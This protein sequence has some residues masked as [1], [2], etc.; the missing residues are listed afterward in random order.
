MVLVPDSTRK[1]PISE[2]D[3]EEYSIGDLYE[4][5]MA[6][7]SVVAPNWT[8][9]SIANPAN[10][11]L[12]VAS[13]LTHVMQQT[14]NVA[15][16][17]CF[18]VTADKREAVRALARPFYAVKELV[19]A[20]SAVQFTFAVPHPEVTIPAR[21]RL[22]T[23]S[24]GDLPV[25][26]FETTADFLVLED[27]AT[28]FVPV[29][30]GESV[31][32]EALGSSDGSTRQKFYLKRRPVVWESEAI[33]VFDGAAWVTWSRVTDFVESLST[34]KHYTIA[35]DN[36][37]WVYLMFGDGDMGAIP[38]AGTNNIRATY[39][40]GGGLQGNVAANTITDLLSV[41][42][43]V[44]SVTNPAAATG[45]ADA[46]S[47][48]KA[49]MVAIAKW[50]AQETGLTA[51]AIAA[52]LVDYVSD[53]YGAI[54]QAVAVGI[55]NLTI[56]VRFVPATGGV[57][58]AG[59]KAEIEAF[60]NQSDIK[61]VLTENKVSDPTFLAVDYDL[62]IWIADGYLRD[63]VIEQVRQAIVR[64]GSPIYRDS[65]GIYPN[66][67]GQIV[68]LS[69]LS[70]EIQNVPGIDYLVINSPATDLTM[71]LYQ[72]RDINSIVIASNLGGVYNSR[73]ILNFEL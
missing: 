9:D 70:R 35:I 21:T 67:F 13:S 28:A 2:I 59:F 51:D 45:G 6:A 65:D 26:V 1:V 4:N 52:L 20:V 68:A 11:I 71:P 23:V 10:Q 39:R 72:I 42:D 33:E 73:T 55:D 48:R 54:A 40:I 32:N 37:G 3:Y 31:I 8:D 7:R 18:L 66:K 49:K 36:Q 62:E 58:S 64:F 22:A 25:I 15:A 24:A 30:Q 53:D 69:K 41:I 56:D 46:E 47:L 17:N 44:Q 63:Q 16:R 27:A 61:A 57:P 29:I 43:N 38:P 14:I 50:R 19:S 34:S 60:L 12:S 5:A